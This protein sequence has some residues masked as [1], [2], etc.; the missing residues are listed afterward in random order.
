MRTM[1]LNRALYGLT[2]VAL[3]AGCSSFSA[4]GGP[5]QLAAPSQ[6]VAALSQLAKASGSA[7]GIE[8]LDVIPI[9][10]WSRAQRAYD[11]AVSGARAKAILEP[12]VSD[13]RVDLLVGTL[14]CSQVEGTAIF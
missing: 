12:S 1:S 4:S 7:C 8:F 10:T 14:R 2:F 11:N 3:L 6:P 13:I 5:Q 9:G